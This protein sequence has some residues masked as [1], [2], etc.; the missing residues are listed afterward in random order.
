MTLV[1]G[2]P[3]VFRD[4]E[5]R[6]RDEWQLRDRVSLVHGLVGK[7][8]G[9]G[10]IFESASFGAGNSLFAIKIPAGVEVPFV[11]LSPILASDDSIDLLKCDIEGSELMLLENYGD[12]LA[13]TRVAVFEFHP[14]FCDVPKC[15]QILAGA[16]FEYHRKIGELD[17]YWKG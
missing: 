16:G 5:S 15:M 3:L 12:L 8:N 2:S 4:L 13:K 9:S 11:D 7:R 17:L 14:H 6:I 10:K 1:E